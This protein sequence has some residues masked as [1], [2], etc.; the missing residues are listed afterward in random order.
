MY[1]DWIQG[2]SGKRFDPYARRDGSILNLSDGKGYFRPD[3][4]D[5]VERGML[6]AY[7]RQEES[8]R[9]SIDWSLNGAIKEL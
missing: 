2:P 7:V 3:L 1:E 8:R 6:A 9:D 5:P 4:D